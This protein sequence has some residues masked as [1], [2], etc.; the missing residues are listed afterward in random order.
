MGKHAATDHSAVHP[1]VAEGLTH[2]PAAAVGAHR[3]G[4]PGI[5][6]GALGWPGEPPGDAP[7]GWPCPPR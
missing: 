4:A 7:I 3:E 5:R 1:L 6:E 2:R